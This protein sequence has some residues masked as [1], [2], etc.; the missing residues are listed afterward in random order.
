[1]RLH[2]GIALLAAWTL[3]GQVIGQGVNFYSI[4]KESALGE[5]LAPAYRDAHPPLDSAM[6][7]DYVEQV[8][9]R[10]MRALPQGSPFL[11]YHFEVTADSTDTFLEPVS[12]PAGY[13]FI[14]AGLILE[15]RDEAEFAGTLAHAM[16]HVLARHYTR[17]QTKSEIAGL[18]AI[19]LGTVPVAAGPNQSIAQS[20]GAASVQSLVFESEA[21]RVAVALTSTA[22]YDPRGLERFIAREQS[23]TPQ[24]GLPPRDDR[25]LTIERAVQALPQQNAPSPDFVRIQEEIRVLTNR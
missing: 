3:N 7:R 14:P 9:Q 2:L 24:P 20:T 6:V 15:A 25:I 8:G 1:M 10:L 22:G 18:A 4:Q 13:I 16:A 21:D 19:P 5:Q 12:F 23:E 17:E 11:P